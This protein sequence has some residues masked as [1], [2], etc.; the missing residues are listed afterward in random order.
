MPSTTALVTAIISFIGFLM[1]SIVMT[2]L[3]LKGRKVY[4][5][6]FSAILLICALWDFGVFLSMIR[7]SHEDELIAYGYVIS[8]PCTLLPALFYHFTGAYLRQIKKKTTIVLWVISLFSVVIVA[9]G[10]FGKISGVYHYHW[11]NLFR[12]DETLLIGNV[13]GFLVYYFALGASLY[14]LMHAY[15][16][17]T[18]KVACRHL[19]YIMTGFIA[20]GLAMFKVVALFNVDSPVL[21]PF[22][23]SLNDIFVALIGIAILKDRLFDITVVVKIGTIYSILAALVIFTFSFSEHLLATYLGELFGGHSTAMH[24]ISIAVVIAVLMPVK[25]RL[26]Q[27]VDKFFARLKVQF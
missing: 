14:S 4:H 15:R 26:E 11:G 27:G 1:N 18:D 10:V 6:L 7:N 8:I 24:L 5:Y 12:P 23:M 25:H 19:L 22:G 20:L 17:E 3:L 13:A 16:L 9:S 21:L 2:F